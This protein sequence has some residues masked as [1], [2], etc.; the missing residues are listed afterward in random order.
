MSEP[1]NPGQS[2]AVLL[3]TA[4]GHHRAARLREAEEIYRRILRENPDQ[5]EALHGVGL[6]ALQVGKAELAAAYLGRAAQ[7][8]PGTAIYYYNQGE[9]WMLLGD[10][11]Q[12]AA[13]LRRAVA[14]DPNRPE[15]HAALGVAWEQMQRFDAAAASLQKALDLGMDRPEVYQHLG[16]ALLQLKRFVEAERF[17]RRAV[18]RSANS[19]EAWQTLGEAL[20][21]L[22]RHDEA[23]ECFRRGLAIKPDFPL[24]HYGLG[25]AQGH[26]ERFD[27]AIDS[28]RTAL[29]LRP[30]YFEALSAL[31]TMLTNKRLLDDAVVTLREALRLRPDHLDT[32]IELARALELARR[33]P[34]AAD[35][36]REI[37]K[38]SPDN[39]N[40]KFHI[41]ALS[42]QEAPPA[43]PPAL[44]TTIF[45]R[46]ADS[47]D[48]HL[49]GQLEYRA[50]LLLYEAVVA[51]GAG[52]SL[53]VLD[54][55]CG[56]GLCG[57]LFRPMAR[58]LIG[59]DLSA[60]MLAKARERNFYDGLEVA[61]VTDALRAAP[62]RYDLLVA[63]DVLCYMGDLSAVF[64]AAAT[65]LRP[66]GLLAFSVET[67]ADSGWLLRPTRRYAH[68]EAY[69]REAAAGAGFRCVSLAQA[70]LRKEA[71]AEVPGLV[72]V[73]RKPQESQS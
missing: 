28:L 50:P 52:Q 42:G 49:L 21:G 8:S 70:A 32:H 63:G 66:D 71:G 65:A 31:G 16:N 39:P 36:F 15:P 12:A 6:L 37:L 44:V 30:K 34:E 57:V 9:A 25:M 22:G 46:H 13:C 47:F 41:A 59:I 4:A 64:S 5:P 24:P 27:E 67:H 35:E 68:A 69:I 73:L 48:E 38:L 18:E 29:R 56:T 43:A 7:L 11:N 55:G 45:E 2:T 19:A 53:D 72:V 17:A 33:Y 40:V 54:L 58:K 20:D 60:A 51:A 10:H 62:A 3:Q 61:E 26:L 1:A 14:L 23:I